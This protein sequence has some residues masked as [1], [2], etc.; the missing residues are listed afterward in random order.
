MDGFKEKKC[1]SKCAVQ[2]KN[3][4]I[5]KCEKLYINGKSCKG[6]W[7]LGDKIGSESADGTLKLYS[8][9]IDG[10]VFKEQSDINKKNFLREVTIQKKAAELGVA[11]Q[12]YEVFLSKNE[13][14]IVMEKMDYTATEFIMDILKSNLT[15]D[16]KITAIFEVILNM[17]SIIETL[18]KHQIL[19]GDIHFGNFMYKNNTLKIIDFG[20]SQ[21]IPKNDKCDYIK[22]QFKNFL[23]IY[24]SSNKDLIQLYPKEMYRIRDMIKKMFKL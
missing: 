22:A 12:I 15:Q 2:Y 19:H 6:V 20:L 14:G 3:G 23:V 11:P 10:Y 7:T 9:N 16:E 4:K 17:V 18:A 8:T 21:K 13:G 24:N 1:S 5:F